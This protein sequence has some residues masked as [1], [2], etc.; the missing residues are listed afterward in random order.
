MFKIKRKW[1][2]FSIFSVDNKRL[3]VNESW[4]ILKSS[5]TIYKIIMFRCRKNLSDIPRMLE[6]WAKLSKHSWVYFLTKQG[7]VTLKFLNFADLSKNV[8][9]Y[10][11]SAQFEMKLFLVLKHL[12]KLFWHK[13]QIPK[14]WDFR[15]QK[16]DHVTLTSKF[17]QNAPFSAC[18]PHI[19]KMCILEL[20]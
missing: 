14:V 5:S 9:W 17:V 3:Q 18:L 13:H 16:S 15:I 11:V 4:S 20:G 8:T 19:F 7:N 10:R 6:S 12:P 1:V 2:S